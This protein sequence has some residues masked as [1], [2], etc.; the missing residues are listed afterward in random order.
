[1]NPSETQKKPLSQQEIKLL[2]TQ[3]LSSDLKSVEGESHE[4]FTAKLKARV[5]PII[6]DL[7]GVSLNDL[8]HQLSTELSN[9][10]NSEELHQK[11]NHEHGIAIRFS[12]DAPEYE[13]IKSTL[14]ELLND[15]HAIE[16]Q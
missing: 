9:D 13:K 14:L 11:L 5:L 3:L 12:E 10:I 4:E 6:K 15:L 2:L 1:M 16:M 8:N 7:E